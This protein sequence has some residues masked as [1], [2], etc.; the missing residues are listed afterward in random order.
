[1]R[2]R[3]IVL[4]IAMVAGA[5][6]SHEGA[7]RHETGSASPTLA[8]HARGSRDGG[9]EPEEP[10]AD[11]RVRVDEPE[12]LPDPGKQVE[13]LGA[14]PAWQAV[15]DRNLYLERRDQHGVVYGTLGAAIT[16]QAAAGPAAGGSAA[17]GSAA[18]GSAAGGSA[19]G[20]GDAGVAE[21]ATPYTWL[22][23][24]V[25]GNGALAIRVALPAAATAKSGDRIALAGAWALDLD[26]H[27][28]WRPTLVIALA[29][30][31]PSKAKDPPASPGHVIANGELPAGARPISVAKE[32]DAASF[33]V[34][35]AAPVA[36]GDGWPV[37]DRHGNPVYAL[38]AMPG[39]RTS[40][41]AQDLRTAD[42][43][44]TLKRGETYWVRIG[45]VHHHGPDKPVTLTAHTAP[46]RVK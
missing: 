43:K 1:M 9:D 18:G 10:R 25:E 33:T 45:P 8:D 44:W 12:P 13:E 32:G 19:A 36:E 46:I 34:V 5:C 24:D 4:V 30:R 7:P 27:W 41:G 28:F 35:G 22:V 31:G 3:R 16:T 29:P 15:V 17:G 2:A 14:V 37:A 6:Q 20:S 23:D 11:A 40:F 38:L 39:E 21:L 26:R 42:E